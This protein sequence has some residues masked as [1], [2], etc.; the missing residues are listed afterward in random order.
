M[1]NAVTATTGTPARQSARP[2][3]SERFGAVDAGELEVHEDEVGGASP[4][5]RTPSSP[6]VA[7]T[8]W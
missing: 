3:L 1:A 2:D 5:S 6:D 7:S 4:A 8:T